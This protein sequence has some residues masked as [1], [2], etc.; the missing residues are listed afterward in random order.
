V[1]LEGIRRIKEAVES[2]LLELQGVT[3]VDIGN[4]MIRGKP[5]HTLAI[6]VYVDCKRN[7]S[8]EQQIPAQIQGVPT[9]VVERD[10][11][12]HRGPEGPGGKT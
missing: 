3:G 10:Y 1:D 12:L 9:D 4:K 8:A 2:E 5:T 7:V 6:R 11:E